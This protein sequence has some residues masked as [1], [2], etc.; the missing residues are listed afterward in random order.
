MTNNPFGVKNQPSILAL[1][2]LLAFLSDRA[3]AQ[4]TVNTQSFFGFES[5][6]APAPAPE[7]RNVRMPWFESY[8]LRTE[9]RDFDF[10]RQEYTFRVSPSTRRKVRAQESLYRH[11]ELA[12]NFDAADD[13]CE[14]L[15]DRYADWV[16]LYFLSLESELLVQLEE[17]RTDQW[18]VLNRLAGTLDFNWSELVKIRE[19]QTD[20]QVDY[21]TV[22]DQK[23]H[24]FA[25][26]ELE[27]KRLDFTD[28]IPLAEV[29]E[30][31]RKT[32]ITPSDTETAYELETINRELELERAEQKQYFDFAQIKYQGPHENPANERLSVGLAVQLPNSGN[33][34]IKVRE[35]ELKAEALRQEQSRD[36]QEAV[37][38]FASRRQLLQEGFGRYDTFSGLYLREKQELEELSQR[39]A[40]KEGVD[41]LPLLEIKARSLRNELK[42]LRLQAELYSAYL[43]LMER[44]GDI[45]AGPRGEVIR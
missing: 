37:A 6:T 43:D 20:L 30:R 34:K 38:D 45:C 14:A 28:L 5:E 13:R 15:A 19:E 35:M 4:A 41:P 8:D 16:E 39:L 40:E 26:Y 11:L 23:A 12:P 2:L 31:V 27:G 3:A 29:R 25:I 33:Q 21:L 44:N 24:F 22:E 42:L 10:D 17:V 7:G 18:T 36:A 9:T 32:E 1:V